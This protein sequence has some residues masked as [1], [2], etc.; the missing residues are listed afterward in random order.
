MFPTDI[1]HMHEAEFRTRGF[2]FL[3]VGHSCV[4]T[5][6]FAVIYLVWPSTTL[7]VLAPKDMIDIVFDSSQ[8]QL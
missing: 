6:S 1:D 8:L 5:R 2:E 4:I 7:Y 3:R